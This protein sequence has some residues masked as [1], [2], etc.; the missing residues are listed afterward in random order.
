MRKSIFDVFE[1][2]SPQK[3][4]TNIQTLYDYEKHYMELVKRY[5]DEINFI[6][7]LLKNYRD[8]QINFFEKQMPAI[9]QKLTVERIDSDMKKLWLKRL[10]E[11][12]S[13]SFSISEQLITN[14]TTKKISEFKEAVN[15]KLHGM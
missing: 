14:Y 6:E 8:E 15:E 3:Q 10:E 1:D 11:N 9:Y 13:R 2:V 7:N 12:M 4:D 5:K